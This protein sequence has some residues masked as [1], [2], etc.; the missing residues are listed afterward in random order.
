MPE[1]NAHVDLLAK[2]IWDYHHLHQPLVKS[3]C[4][5]VLGSHDH[6]VAEYAAKLFLEGW[7]PLFIISG[8]LGHLT[9]GIWDEP[10]ADKFA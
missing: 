8:G 1:T 4:L 2:K 10:E 6:R 9:E 3:D 7:S 5:L